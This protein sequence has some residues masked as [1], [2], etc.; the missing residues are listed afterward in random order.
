MVVIVVVVV[1]FL[2]SSLFIKVA[3]TELYKMNMI[4][5]VF[6]IEKR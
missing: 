6:L 2:V 5:R 1:V 3:Y 4:L